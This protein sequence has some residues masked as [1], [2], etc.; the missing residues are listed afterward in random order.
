MNEVAVAFVRSFFQAGKPIAAI[1]HAPWMLVEADIARGRTLTSY[2]SLRT[3]IR[4]AGGTWVDEEVHVE[5][6]IVTSRRPRDL[7]VFCAK[8]LEELH[9]GVAPGQRAATG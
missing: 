1:C 2:P 4:N 8:L 7:P 6:R 9:Q 3:D 5:E